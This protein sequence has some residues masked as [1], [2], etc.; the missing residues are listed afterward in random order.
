MGIMEYFVVFQINNG[1]AKIED[2]Y[3]HIQIYIGENLN[4]K[5]LGK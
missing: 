1:N 3:G 2:K 5:N 4:R